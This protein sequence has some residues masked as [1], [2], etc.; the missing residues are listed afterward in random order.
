MMPT[1]PTGSRVISTSMPGR[2]DGISSPVRRRTSPAKN[3][4][5]LA[6]ADHFAGA[7]GQGLAL[8]ARQQLAQLVLARQDLVADLVEDVGARLRVERSPAGRRRASGGDGLVDLLRV[9]L[10]VLAHHVAQVRGIDVA[11][12]V[13]APAPIRRRC[14]WNAVESWLCPLCVLGSPGGHSGVAFMRY[15][16]A[17]GG[18]GSPSL[19]NQRS[20]IFSTSPRPVQTRERAVG[21][22]PEVRVVAADH[23]A[24]GL[25]GEQLIDQAELLE[26]ARLDQ[27]ADQDHA[28]G[29]IGAHLAGLERRQCPR[30]GP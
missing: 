6:G 10:G 17:S 14:S 21:H 22:E 29:S 9:R 15:M 25:V 13:A 7:L 23:E 27:Q 16:A 5:M 20:K 26:L 1:T 18:V 2:T 30:R 8:L 12:D 11:G 4:K 19:P 28:V 3:L 24:V